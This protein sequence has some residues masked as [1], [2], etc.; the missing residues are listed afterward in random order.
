V[1]IGF[2]HGKYSRFLLVVYLA[3]R[4]DSDITPLREALS[5]TVCVTCAGAG[6]AKPSS[7]KKAKAC[8]TAWDVRRVPSVRCTLCWLRCLEDAHGVV[9]VKLSISINSPTKIPT[10]P[11]GRTSPYRISEIS[12]LFW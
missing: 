5:S 11:A 7:Q 8:K 6:T 3:L 2:Q 12:M 10:E 4:L 9:I 1:W